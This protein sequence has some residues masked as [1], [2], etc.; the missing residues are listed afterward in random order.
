MLAVMTT[1]LGLKS[2]YDSSYESKHFLG[3]EMVAEEDIAE[4]IEGKMRMP[5]FSE[6][7]LYS[8]AGQN[9]ACPCDEMAEKIYIAQSLEEEEWCGKLKVALPA[10][11]RAYLVKDLMMDNKNQ[12]IGDNHSFR[13]V[14]LSDKSYIECELVICGGP[15]MSI[16]GSPDDSISYLQIW[17]PNAENQRER[18]IES[19]CRFHVR[20]LTSA[21]FD[22][23]GYKLI[24]CDEK[25]NSQKYKLLEM[26]EDDDWVLNAMYSD[27]SKLRE[28]L[29][30]KVWEMAN[31]LENVP[32]KSTG[33]EYVELILNNEYHGLYGL[34]VP[35]DKKLFNM[36]T[37]DITYV[38]RT[39][40]T[41]TQ[42]EFI[43]Q[44][45]L[46]YQAGI[47]MRYADEQMNMAASWA[48][49]KEYLEFC[50]WEHKSQDIQWD[51][52]AE[53]VDINN[54]ISYDII[55]NL[56]TAPDNIWKNTQFI[57]YLNDSGKYTMYQYLW[58]INY[59]FGDAYSTNSEDLYVRTL[60]NEWLGH[61]AAF[62]SLMSI[63]GERTAQQTHEKWT[64]YN[65]N[66]INA[67]NLC[68][69]TD[70]YFEEMSSSGALTRDSVRWPDS[71]NEDNT[72]NIK[73]WIEERF[74]FLDENYDAMTVA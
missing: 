52:V 59:S 39:W 47:E 14:I 38:A 16:V 15:L 2:S 54:V 51:V 29:G 31:D 56:I 41:P 12:A 27:S 69:L 22:K 65:D 49:M 73:K 18:I 44:L 64:F 11:Y 57:A 48:P 71:K 36:K 33:L 13:I 45:E 72:E 21:V 20:G 9:Y 10:S 17:N 3:L 37:G 53:C 6:L 30:Y 74:A 8:Y 40:S 55:V 62:Q 7:L 70:A 26:R 42:E 43:S 32:F 25:G 67:A 23:K 28:K 58:D 63:D 61:T 19:S 35:I 4:L 50:V 60:S 24:L 46:P 68:R 5:Y 66:G 1:Y 34:S